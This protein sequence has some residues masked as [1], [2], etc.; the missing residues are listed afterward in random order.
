[1]PMGTANVCL[2]GSV[3]RMASS[4]TQIS[5][6]GRMTHAVDLDALERPIGTVAVQPGETWYFQ[7]WFREVG[8]QTGW[9]EGL[10]V[11]FR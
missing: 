10:G 4:L 1:M 7:L 3:G 8:L 2:G 11:T 6:S 9:S 5:A